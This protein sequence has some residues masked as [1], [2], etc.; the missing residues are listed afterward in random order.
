MAEQNIKDKTINWQRVVFSIL[1]LLLSV[2][3]I[4]IFRDKIFYFQPYENS[5]NIYRFIWCIA[6]VSLGF[7]V[8]AFALRHHKR[9][10]LPEYITHYPAQLIAM[11]TLV[12]GV[13]HIFE[14]TRGY[15]FYYLSFSL[16]FTLGYLVDSYWSF[17]ISLINRGH[18]IGA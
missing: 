16:C 12:F 7:S 14:A 3:L 4:Y 8:V 6:G 1:Y 17:V 10:P 5:W 2:L 11:A 13:L 9:T 18:K 15:L